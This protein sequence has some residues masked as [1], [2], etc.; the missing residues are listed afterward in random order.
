MYT[1]N[2]FLIATRK[3]L[4]KLYVIVCD[5]VAKLSYHSSTPEIDAFHQYFL[6]ISE[7]YKQAYSDWKSAFDS[8]V[9]KTATV[10]DLLD[11]F[12][13][14]KLPVWD[15]MI[16]AE[17]MPYSPAY[18]ALMRQGRSFFHNSKK[19]MKIESI[20][21]LSQNLKSYPTLSVLQEEV[22][23]F[24]NSI[25][26]AQEEKIKLEKKV[27]EK[28]QTLREHRVDTCV[29]L[30]RNL[31]HLIGISPMMPQRVTDFF[32]MELVRTNRTTVSKAE[33]R[34]TEHPPSTEEE[35]L[36]DNFLFNDTEPVEDS[37][38]E[39]DFL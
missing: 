10:N 8:W 30:Y 18:K 1:Q 13:K 15:A 21:R 19:Q 31:T 33:L 5:Y 22:E 28:L 35:I 3:S 34:E 29:G 20:L 7:S 39:G 37:R 23:T 16:Q 17:V 27:R 36:N 24:A 26:E 2:P 12:L 38:E 6:P 25:R 14:K 32:L 4:E 9:A 11:T